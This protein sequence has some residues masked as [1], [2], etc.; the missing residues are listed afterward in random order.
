M[1]EISIRRAAAADAPAVVELIE[2]LADYEYLDP[3][4]AAASTRLAA[5]MA[6]AKPRFD[7][8]LAEYDGSPAGF[9]LV[10]ETYSSF[11]ARPKLYIEDLFVLSE[12]RGRGVG[13]ALFEAMV[14]EGKKRGC[15]LLE[16]TALDWNTPAHEFYKKMGGRLLKAWQVYRLNL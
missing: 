7:A 9:A 11:L 10:F 15:S 12:C 6:S 14:E 5:E 2:A 3:P 13:R 8:F 1:P 16:W 4:D